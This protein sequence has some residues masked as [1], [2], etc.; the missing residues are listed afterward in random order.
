VG[1]LRVE[2]EQWFRLSSTLSLEARDAGGAEQGLHEERIQALIAERLAARASRQFAA[3]DRI[4]EQLA[5]A[6]VV[7][8]DQPDGGTLWKRI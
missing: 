8:E 4:R 1:L 7:L 3:A 5:L 6:G 2:P